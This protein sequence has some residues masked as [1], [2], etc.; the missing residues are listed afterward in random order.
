V[1]K[2]VKKA[3]AKKKAPN[4]L[5]I[6]AMKTDVETLKA[7]VQ[8]LDARLRTIEKKASPPEERLEEK[9]MEEFPGSREDSLK[10]Y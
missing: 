9:K 4:I 1:A 2:K 8:N 3:K 10:D 5:G 6:K 7:K